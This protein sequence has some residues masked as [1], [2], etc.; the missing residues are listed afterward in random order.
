MQQWGS[1]LGCVSATSPNMRLDDGASRSSAWL[2]SPSD[3]A[4]ST[5][6]RYALRAWGTS[7]AAF[8]SRASIRLRW[9]RR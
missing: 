4:R 1:L 9:S 2:P 6:A 7:R 5:A 8:P 3:A